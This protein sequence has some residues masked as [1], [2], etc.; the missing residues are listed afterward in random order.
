VPR[1]YIG[2]SDMRLHVVENLPPTI[3]VRLG[4]HVLRVVPIAEI[5]RVDPW[6]HRLM[7]R[8]RQRSDPHR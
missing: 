4:E 5:E 7:T 3:Q 1:W 8:W 6:L 2:L